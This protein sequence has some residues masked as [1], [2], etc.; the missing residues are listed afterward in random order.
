MQ[1]RRL[2]HSDLRV[3]ILGLGTSGLGTRADLRESHRILDRARD[4]GMT[5][6]DTAN[7][8][9]RGASESAIGTWL[10]QHRSEVIIATKAGLPVGD[11]ARDRGAS[12]S[13]LTR[14][15]EGS[16]RRLHTDY[17]DLYQVHTFDPVTPLDETLQTLQD[18][19]QEGKVRC[20][21]ASNYRAWELMKALGISERRQL[22][23]FVSHQCS[24]SL[25]DRTPE[26]EM[27]PLL[28]DQGVSLIAYFPLGSG[29]LT[30]KY[31]PG[32]PAPPGSRGARATGTFPYQ[33][34]ALLAL[35]AEVEA[36]ADEIQARPAH[37]ALAWL[38]HHAEVASTIAG[39][40]LVGQLEE[41]LGA[42]AIT[43]PDD[44]RRRLDVASE[45]FAHGEPLGDYR[46][47]ERKDG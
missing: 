24:Y 36:V 37:V 35:A 22:V 10:P 44:A 16:L 34:P 19:V 40:R 8:Y 4:A 28:R 47:D 7:V 29:L 23:S 43:L 45:R 27:V 38:W 39:A 21:G 5:L 2:G 46:I 31:R 25:A 3:S 12:R 41:N 14:E 17:I 26:R 13:H 9:G 11:T 42:L 15:L 33:D 1:Y 6:I 32:E 18:F 20:V 30:G